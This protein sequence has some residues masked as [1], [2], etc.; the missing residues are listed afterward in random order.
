[1]TSTLSRIN[2][3]EVGTTFRISLVDDS[4][5]VIDVSTASPIKIFFKKP[6]GTKI[7]K[8]AS[9]YTDGS[10]G[11]IQYESQIGDIDF[12]GQWFMQ[13]YVEIEGDKFFSEISA[14]WVDNTLYTE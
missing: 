12:A 6:H 4:G 5:E 9:F 1:M 14:F 10:D 8:E 2:L 11:I 7:A 3:G 13:G